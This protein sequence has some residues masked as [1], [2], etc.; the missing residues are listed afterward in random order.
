M[1]ILLQGQLFVVSSE[2]IVNH[3][4][5]RYLPLTLGQHEDHFA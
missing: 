4:A 2:P 3:K 1:C 5:D